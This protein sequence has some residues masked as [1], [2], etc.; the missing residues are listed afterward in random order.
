MSRDF[1]NEENLYSNKENFFLQP[2]NLSLHGNVTEPLRRLND[3]DSNI[4]QQ[5]AYKDVK[6][7]LFKLEYKLTR[8]EEE[9][10]SLEAQIQSAKDIHDF[11]N[12]EILFIRQKQLIEEYRELSEIYNNTSL[13][14]KISGGIFN[15]VSHRLKTKYSGIRKSLDLLGGLILSKLP[16][17]F[18]QALEIRKSLGKLENINKS[19]DELMTLQTPYGEGGDKY[20]QLSKYITKA[21][22]I[23]SEISRFLK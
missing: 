5:E 11:K 2:E 6:D 12:A 9:L 16:K 19:V 22:Y 20:I 3:Y 1:F 14:A 21:N 18:S 8:T 13:S 4:L 15:K 23:Q 17:R 7:E 10:K